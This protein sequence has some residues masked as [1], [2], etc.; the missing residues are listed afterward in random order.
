[1]LV[2]QAIDLPG[3]TADQTLSDRLAVARSSLSHL[4]CAARSDEFV[5]A[6]DAGGDSDHSVA[7]APN[8]AGVA[9]WV[10]NSADV[11]MGEDG[12]YARDQQEIYAAQ[13]D[14]A[15][16]SWLPGE[17][18][19]RHACRFSA[20]SFAENDK[21]YVVWIHENDDGNELMFST[22]DGSGWTSPATLPITG[23]APG[24][25]FMALRWGASRRVRSTCCST[26]ACRTPTARS[27][28]SSTT[29]RI[30]Q[31]IVRRSCNHRNRRPGRQLFPH[32]R[33]QPAG[34]IAPGELETATV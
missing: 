4:G 23:L 2:Y 3:A 14:D 16:Q 31:R 34:W 6:G 19:H 32:P 20:G 9:A 29:R 5:L 27:T 25:Q 13:W 21:L 15:T 18:V 28:A 12:E 22:N 33:H 30:R 17:A 10:H 1:M 8:G 7:F 24:G 26:I 11:P